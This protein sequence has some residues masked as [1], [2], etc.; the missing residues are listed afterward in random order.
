VDISCAF[1]TELATPQHIAVAESLDY[2]RAWWHDSPAV[3]PDVWM[4]LA[5]AAERTSRIGLGPGVLIPSLLGIGSGFTGR[6]SMGRRPMRWA[7]VREY[8]QTLRALLRGETATW[9]GRPARDAAPRP[10]VRTAA[11]AAPRAQLVWG[12]VLLPGEHP[13][14]VRV[15][16]TLGPAT[17]V[18][19][20]VIYE[21]GGADAVD[22]CPAAARGGNGSR[23]TPPTSGTSR[24]ATRSRRGLPTASPRSRSSRPARTSP[25]S[26]NASSRP[27]AVGDQ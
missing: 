18:M 19:Y 20:H 21:R 24:C 12:S 7:D 2:H 14:S 25:V 13:T 15:Q 8:V 23:R 27:R 17:A 3:Y 10:L 16:E 26:W 5:L 1:A 6:V 9:E 22:R 4:I 11:D